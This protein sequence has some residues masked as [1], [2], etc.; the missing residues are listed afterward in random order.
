MA[1]VRIER[2]ENGYEVE[3]QDPAIVK[4]N[5]G[6]DKKGNRNSWKNPSRSYGFKSVEEVTAFLEKNLDKALP[7]DDYTASFDEAVAAEKD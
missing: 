1:Y 5:A 4:Q 6:Y 7:Q 3:V 2:M